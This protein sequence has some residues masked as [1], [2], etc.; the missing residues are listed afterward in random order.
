MLRGEH[1]CSGH[2]MTLIFVIVSRGNRFCNVLLNPREKVSWIKNGS[3]EGRTF[4]IATQILHLDDIT[5]V[6]F[7]MQSRLLLKSDLTLP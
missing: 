6:L 2:T 1:P 4:L 3:V 5:P 7:F